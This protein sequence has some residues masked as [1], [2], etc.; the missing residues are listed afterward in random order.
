MGVKEKEIKN[1]P[2]FTS[3]GKSRGHIHRGVSSTLPGFTTF[4][5]G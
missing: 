2:E 3:H 1:W 5:P 4:C